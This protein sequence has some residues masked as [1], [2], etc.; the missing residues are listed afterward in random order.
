MILKCAERMQIPSLLPSQGDIV[1]LAQAID[2]VNLTK[3]TDEEKTRL[4]IKQDENGNNVFISFPSVNDFDTDIS[5]NASQLAFLKL[6]ANKL[7]A[8]SKVTVSNLSL[9]QKILAA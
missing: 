1:S 9:V 7:N 4:A 8:D 3:L 5:L 6:H 2:I